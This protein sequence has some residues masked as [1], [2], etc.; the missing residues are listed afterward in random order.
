MGT[1]YYRCNYSENLLFDEMLYDVLL[2]TVLMDR[3]FVL[4]NTSLVNMTLEQ[5]A[6]TN[7]N[8]HGFVESVRLFFLFTAEFSTDI[9][10][11]DLL[12]ITQASLITRYWEK[13]S[14]L[15]E[16]KE[17]CSSL[18]WAHTDKTIKKINVTEIKK[19]L[20]YFNVE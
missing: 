13:K 14:R 8:I 6:K 20:F 9:R 7:S 3:R 12:C 5:N 11:G 2:L 10:N 16:K 17:R 15:N 19:K 18:T 4:S 1:W